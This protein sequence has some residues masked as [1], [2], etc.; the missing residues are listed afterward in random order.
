MQLLYIV[1]YILY[2]ILCKYIC[3]RSHSISNSAVRQYHT[4]YIIQGGCNSSSSL[5]H[6]FNQ[7]KNSNK[8][9]SVIKMFILRLTVFKNGLTKI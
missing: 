8:R 5:T 3:A 4:T 6:I 1:V 2:I 7:L 9:F